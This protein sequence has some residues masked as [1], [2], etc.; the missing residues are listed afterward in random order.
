MTSGWDKSIANRRRLN[1]RIRHAVLVE[2][3]EVDRR[4]SRNV[5]RLNHNWHR[6]NR[7][8]GNVRK[9][10]RIGVDGIPADA[11]D[12]RGARSNSRQ[13]LLPTRRLAEADAEI[14]L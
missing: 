13:R 14:L 7:V 5:L 8:D 12:L 1:H 4:S 9:S 6:G 3:R 10:I 11:D 2:N